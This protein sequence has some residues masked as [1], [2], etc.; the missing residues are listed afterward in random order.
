MKHLTRTS[1]ARS[2]TLT[3][4]PIDVPKAEARAQKVASLAKQIENLL[5]KHQ[6]VQLAAFV[7]GAT[8]TQSLD[9]SLRKG[10]HR[11]ARMLLTAAVW[12]VAD[13]L[14]DGEPDDGNS[15]TTTET[16]PADADA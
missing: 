4:T 16:G 5:Q 15:D 1:L 2:P 13:T 10:D 7:L 12:E 9:H 11:H 14:V 3:M 6:G 8:D